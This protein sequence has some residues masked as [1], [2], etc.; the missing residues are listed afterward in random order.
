MFISSSLVSESSLRREGPY[1]KWLKASRGGSAKGIAVV[2]VSAVQA[3]PEPLQSLSRASL[4]EG[5]KHLLTAGQMRLPLLAERS[6]RVEQSRGVIRH[7]DRTLRRRPAG[8]KSR[9]AVGLQ[10]Q[11]RQYA[12]RKL[13]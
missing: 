3:A 1:G 4:R 2:K 6:D 10:L 5:I 13:R 12:S 8:P 9:I 11:R 7:L